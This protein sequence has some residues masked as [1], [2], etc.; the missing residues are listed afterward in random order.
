MSITDLTTTRTVAAKRTPSGIFRMSK[1]AL[2]DSDT[3][4]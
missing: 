4:N 2:A 3:A 1:S